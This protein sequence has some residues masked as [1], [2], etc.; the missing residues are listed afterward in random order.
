[1]ASQI[2]D[3]YDAMSITEIIGNM[4]KSVSMGFKAAAQQMRFPG[5]NHWSEIFLGS[6]QRLDFAKAV[7]DGRGNA[8]L[9]ASVLWA[10][11][12]FPEAP[13][14]LEQIKRGG[15]GN[16]PLPD[17][18][19]IALLDIPNPFYAGPLLWH[20]TIVD[21]MFGNAYWRKI[22]GPL[23][24]VVQLWWIPSFLIEP[25]WSGSKSYVDFYE[26][27]FDSTEKPE[28]IDPKDIVHFK[29][30]LDPKNTRKG[31]SPLGA[32]IREIFTD[33]EGANYTAT[34]LSNLGVPGMVISPGS[35]NGKVAPADAEMIKQQA[36]QKFTNQNRGRTLVLSTKANV[37]ILSFN[38]QQMQVRELRRIP[39]ERVT[40]I[41]GIPAI[42]VGL[43]AGLDRS[44]YSNMAEAREAAYESFMIPNQRLLAAEIKTQLLPDFVTAPKQFKVFF[45]LSE[46]R[47]LQTDEN[48]LHTRAGN[49]LAKG[50]VMLDEARDLIGMSPLPNN[51]GQ[52]FYLPMASTPT[53]PDELWQE[54]LPVPEALV[55]PSGPS[56]TGDD[57]DEETP[58]NS[59]EPPGATPPEKGAPRALQPVGSNGHNPPGYRFLV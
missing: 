48:D 2:D 56:S 35:D 10:A 18:E 12:N 14:A 49:D 8:L 36:E 30:G 39:E 45:D 42:V 58:P 46:V 54:P 51:Q 41:L 34:L 19:L 9:M 43:G 33:D 50:M 31:L 26:Y 21:W 55:A 7:G 13:L 1:M 5:R 47:V 27:K 57:L 22:R 3:R 4:G 38:P 15:K 23:N 6:Q 24:R 16:I 53:K 11:R 32:L 29:N 28:I 37:N 25:K 44:T 59:E 52:L 40:A 20:G 17:H